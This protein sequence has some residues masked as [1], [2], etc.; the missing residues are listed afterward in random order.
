MWIVMAVCGMETWGHVAACKQLLNC[1]WVLWG[2]LMSQSTQSQQ[3]ASM[4]RIMFLG[5]EGVFEVIGLNACLPSE[6]ASG[7]QTGWNTEEMFL[8]PSWSWSRRVSSGALLVPVLKAGEILMYFKRRTREP[9]RQ[10]VG[11][12]KLLG[13]REKS[14][15][16]GHRTRDVGSRTGWWFRRWAWTTE[17]KI[18]SSTQKL[19]QKRH[20]CP[21]T[22]TN[23]P[24]CLVLIS[25]V[26][27]STEAVFIV[28]FVLLC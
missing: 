8:F 24:T 1:S 16:K 26:G 4:A 23:Q 11:E 25:K 17:V 13:L 22:K 19:K 10:T 2:H 15:N 21:F 7:E 14:N 18:Q 9:K 6:S 12:S 28:S 5:D 27:L 3:S 20:K